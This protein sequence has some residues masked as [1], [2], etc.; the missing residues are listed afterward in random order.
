M[1]DKLMKGPGSGPGVAGKPAN[2]YDEEQKAQQ[3][4]QVD[5]REMASKSLLGGVEASKQGLAEMQ[6]ANEAAPMVIRRQA[7][8]GLA[9]AQG[10]VPGGG[11]G[12]ALGNIMQS[13]RQAGLDEAQYNMGAAQQMA[14][15]RQ[16][17][18][19]QQTEAYNALKEMGTQTDESRA[20]I[21][22][23]DAR[24]NAEI[25]KYKSWYGDDEKGAAAA[26]RQLASQY[27]DEAVIQHIMAQ[28]SKVQSG[29]WDF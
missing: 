19:A 7:A 20:Q 18:A 10:G 5:L 15:A 27:T 23:A 26:L 22:E 11:S 1:A 9:A 25:Q 3:Q 2:P 17:A 8:Q 6:K 29:A 13:G 24:I 4:G 12:S 28:A 14:D 16:A 21:V